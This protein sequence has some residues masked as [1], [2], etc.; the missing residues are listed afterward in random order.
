MFSY[1]PFSVTECSTGSDDAVFPLNGRTAFLLRFDESPLIVHAPLV[2]SNSIRHSKIAV[3][4]MTWRLTPNHRHTKWYTFH[5]YF[6]CIYKNKPWKKIDVFSKT[7]CDTHKW[8]TFKVYH[9][10]K[11]SEIHNVLHAVFSPVFQ[12]YLNCSV[13]KTMKNIFACCF[14]QNFAEAV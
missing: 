7:W 9:F 2:E 14:L 10:N 4:H 6:S 11:L 5:I 13:L 1:V 8:S 12:R 3:C